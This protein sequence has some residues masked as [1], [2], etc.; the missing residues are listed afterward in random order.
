VANRWRTSLLSRSP[1]RSA[2]KV[3]ALALALALAARP[4]GLPSDSTNE[5]SKATSERNCRTSLARLC[6]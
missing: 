2:S 3:L 1:L 4:K 5:R 6:T